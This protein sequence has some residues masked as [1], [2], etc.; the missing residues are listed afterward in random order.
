[1]YSGE[2]ISSVNFVYS[3]GKNRAERVIQ[4]SAYSCWSIASSRS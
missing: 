1:M 2:V 3:S 4:V